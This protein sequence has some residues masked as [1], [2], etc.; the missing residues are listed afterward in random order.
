MVEESDG[1]LMGD[2]VNVA[3]RLEQLGP[4][5]GVLVSG[6]AYDQ[7]R[8]KLDLPLDFAGDQRVKNISQPVRTSN[9]RIKG[10]KPAWQLRAWAAPVSVIGVRGD[11]YS[12]SRRGWRLVVATNGGRPGDQTRYCC[13]PFRQH[14]RR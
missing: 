12:H 6:A 1:D 7:L 11:R 8:G 5:G 13:A 2:G 10:T 4:P 9:V 3:A 14:W